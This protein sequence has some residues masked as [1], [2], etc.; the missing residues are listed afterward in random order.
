MAIIESLA[1]GIL[2]GT[3]VA[4][5]NNF[6]QSSRENLKVKIE[7]GEHISGKIIALRRIICEQAMDLA[8]HMPNM[9]EC[10]K[11]GPKFGSESEKYK[12]FEQDSIEL[13]KI[14]MIHFPLAYRYSVKMLDIPAALAT[15]YT[16]AIK[17]HNGIHEKGFRMDDAMLE[18]IEAAKQCRSLADKTTCEIID[19][20]RRAREDNIYP[21]TRLRVFIGW[22]K[23]T[24]LLY[25]S[26][27]WQFL[28]RK[29]TA[30]S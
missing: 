19:E 1:V 20:I 13:T 27:M 24:T 29:K 15:I 9:E 4:I 17:Y 10:L 7:K 21:H 26:K 11:H 12:Q 3:I 28:R 8:L 14:V 2:S 6:F 25:K 16:K 22:I 18:A 30:I 23:N 5:A